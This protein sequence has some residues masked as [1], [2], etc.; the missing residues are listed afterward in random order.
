MKATRYVSFSRDGISSS[1][2]IVF[3]KDEARGHFFLP[4]VVLHISINP[5]T[6]L[7][8]EQ[9]NNANEI[10]MWPDLACERREVQ[11]RIISYI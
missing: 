8:N 2:Q 1:L 11:S 7:F 6:D 3:K 4:P 5:S 10:V 9:K